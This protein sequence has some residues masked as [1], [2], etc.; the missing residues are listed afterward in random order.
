MVVYVYTYLK[1][2]A[3]SSVLI[4]DKGPPISEEATIP[5]RGSHSGAAASIYGSNHRLLL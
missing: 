4:V 5:F 3:T 2:P 1:E